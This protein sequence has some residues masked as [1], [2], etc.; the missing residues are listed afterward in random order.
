MHGSSVKGTSTDAAPDEEDAVARLLPQRATARP[1]NAL[2]A[3]MD[4]ISR[5][6]LLDGSTRPKANR[7]KEISSRQRQS[8]KR[9]AM[10][11]AMHIAALDETKEMMER[12]E[13]LEAD[14]SELAEKL[15]S[16]EMVRN[17]RKFG[18]LCGRECQFLDFH[19]RSEDEQIFPL[20]TAKGDDSMKRVVDRLMQEHAIVHELL[21]DLDRNVKAIAQHPSA[22][23][24][25]A[26][27]QTF[28]EL[29]RF[30][31]SHFGYE[32]GELEEALGFFDVPL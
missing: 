22:G 8:G 3:M 17:Y 20:L 11:H 9:L 21:V 10:I 31:R 2:V 28:E 13:A 6:D 32:E 30:V 16:L 27:K 7:I 24:F 12:V 26:A 5:N 15:A 19:H 23:T 4:T 25:A 18:N 1:S 14:T 29:Y